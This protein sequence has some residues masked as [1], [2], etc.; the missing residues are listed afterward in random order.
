MR[1]CLV[2]MGHTIDLRLMLDKARHESFS[3]V[4]RHITEDQASGLE[5]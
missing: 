1:G 2:D 4:I 5:I 3:W